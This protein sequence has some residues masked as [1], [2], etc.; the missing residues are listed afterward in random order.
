[1]IDEHY[2]SVPLVDLREDDGFAIGRRGRLTVELSWNTIGNV[3]WLA[4]S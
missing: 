2:G 4:N 1:V 3:F